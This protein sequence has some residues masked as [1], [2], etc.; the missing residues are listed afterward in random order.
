MENN[1]KN[2]DI[3]ELMETQIIKESGLPKKM[4]TRI[5]KKMNIFDVLKNKQLENIHGVG[6]M[7]AEIISKKLKEYGIDFDNKEQ[8]QKLIDEYNKQKFPNG[9]NKNII[10]QINIDK[11]KIILETMIE[12]LDLSVRSFNVLKRAGINTILDLIRRDSMDNIRYMCTKSVKEIKERLLEYGIDFD[13]KEQC[14]E[15]IKQYE[16]AKQKNQI[17]VNE[18]KLQELNQ[19]TNDNESLENELT[20]KQKVLQELKEQ[21]ERRKQLEQQLAECDKEYSKLIKQYNSLNSKESS[22]NHGTK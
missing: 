12:D 9:E 16:E 1:K 20:I 5:G 13:D 10:K 18:K 6:Q 11:I 17:T 2:T 14:R 22:N 3:I 19:V 4:I 21:L 15:L 8:C 7:A